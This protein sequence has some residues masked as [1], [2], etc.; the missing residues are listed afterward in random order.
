M[1]VPEGKHLD[2]LFRSTTFFQNSDNDKNAS[3]VGNNTE[4]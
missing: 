3:R 1:E 4:T 2:L